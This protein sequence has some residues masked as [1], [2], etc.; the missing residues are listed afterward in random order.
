M[1]KKTKQDNKY[2]EILSTIHSKINEIINNYKILG[3]KFN[4]Y[5]KQDIYIGNQIIQI[6]LIN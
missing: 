2:N 3:N 4:E 1:K 5:N 6:F